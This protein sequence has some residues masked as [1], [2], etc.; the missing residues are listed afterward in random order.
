MRMYWPSTSRPLRIRFRVSHATARSSTAGA[1]APGREPLLGP[2]SRS[3]TGHTGCW[4][5]G[6][7][8]STPVAGWGAHWPYSDA[9][10]KLGEEQPGD[11]VR[12]RTV[13][14]RTSL[15]SSSG[16]GIEHV[17]DDVNDER[18]HRVVAAVHRTSYEPGAVARSRGAV[19]WTD[20]PPALVREHQFGAGRSSP[21]SHGRAG[22][23]AGR[24]GHRAS[25]CVPRS[26]RGWTSRGLSA[27]VHRRR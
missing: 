5:T 7:R 18:W 21:G 27:G 24:P 20:S 15:V 22:S 4:H 10:Q 17:P 26:V 11:R 3:L 14:P 19:T 12:S 25:G 9:L 6:F 8:P 16:L 1:S 23:V 13:I 2:V